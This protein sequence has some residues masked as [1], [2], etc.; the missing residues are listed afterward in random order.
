MIYSLSSLEEA[1]GEE[2]VAEV[3]VGSDSRSIWAEV[4]GEVS[5]L[6]WEAAVGEDSKERKNLWK[7]ISLEC[8][9]YI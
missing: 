6:I 9:M 7:K 3:V 2:E 1:W 8:Q 5:T 4:A